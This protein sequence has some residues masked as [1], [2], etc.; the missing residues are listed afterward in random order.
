MWLA[1]LLARYDAL[2]RADAMS[3]RIAIDLLNRSLLTDF[4]R[5]RASAGYRFPRRS[6]RAAAPRAD[7]RRR[8]R[9][10]AAAADARRNGVSKRYYG[11]NAGSRSMPNGLAS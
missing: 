10:F 3:R 9:R 11:A 6:H 5:S 1:A 4:S 7:A 2:R 8:R